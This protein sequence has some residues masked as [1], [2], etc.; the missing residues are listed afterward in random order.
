MPKLY[1]L[2]IQVHPDG[3]IGACA[4]FYNEDGV[5]PNGRAYPLDSPDFPARSKKT[6]ADLI[7]EQTVALVEANDMMKAK[8]AAEEEKEEARAAE[9]AEAKTVAQVAV[10]RAVALASQLSRGVDT[11]SLGG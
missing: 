3:K 10:S 7:G 5:T 2:L 8:M 9:L 6:V 11:R 4:Y 1:Q